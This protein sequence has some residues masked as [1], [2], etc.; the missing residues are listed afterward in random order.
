MQ[1]PIC[2]QFGFFGVFLL[3]WFKTCVIRN[4][5]EKVRY[6]Y[7]Q[8]RI[9][10]AWTSILGGWLQDFKWEG[11]VLPIVLCQIQFSQ[12]LIVP[13][14]D[15][16]ILRPFNIL[17]IVYYWKTTGTPSHYKNVPVK[18]LH[19]LKTKN[20][21]ADRTSQ[22]KGSLDGIYKKTDCKS[23]II[24]IALLRNTPTTHFHR[25]INLQSVFFV[26][27]V[28]QNVILAPVQSLRVQVFTPESEDNITEL[29]IVTICFLLCSVMFSSG[30][31]WPRLQLGS[32]S[33][34]SWPP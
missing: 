19:I 27:S 15:I 11:S 24:I 16:W 26:N 22:I 12:N 23:I 29:S 17:W 33:H 6:G 34:I 2:G 1:S 7:V 21:W 14:R 5:P 20:M 4:F 10:V 25:G 28:P 32:Y 30:I 18:K 8:R 3:I 9:H 31:S 13:L